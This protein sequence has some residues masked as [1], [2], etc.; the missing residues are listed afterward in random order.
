MSDHLSSSDEDMQELLELI[1]I[2]KKIT[3]EFANRFANSEYY[4]LQ[5]GD[6]E[7]V[8]PLKYITVF[9]WFAA[10]EATLFRDVSD[11]NLSPEIIKWPDDMEKAE[12]ETHF[13]NNNFPGV[14]GII[15]GTHIKIDKPADDPDSY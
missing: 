8:T 13:R 10:N 7:K 1:E 15:D 3:E 2:P 5:N 14:I 6:S 11:S 9:L 4:K 12:I